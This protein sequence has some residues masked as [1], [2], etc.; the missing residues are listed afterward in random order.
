M[1]QP[2]RKRAER[3]HLLGL[4]QQ[5]F[6]LSQ[7]R[8]DGLQDGQCGRGAVCQHLLEGISANL[9]H[10]A[11]PGGAHRGGP[12]RM[13]Q[14]RHFAEHLAALPNGNHDV[15]DIGFLDNL[16][17][18]VRHHI[19]GVARCAL[20]D[21]RR[22]GA[23]RSTAPCRRK[24]NRD[25]AR[26][27]RR[28]DRSGAADPCSLSAQISLNGSDRNAAL[29]GGACHTVGGAQADVAGGEDARARSSPGWRDP[30]PAASPWAACRPSS[31]RS[32]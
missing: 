3:R 13:I 27:V 26:I 32:L 5:A 1:R 11:V 20:L 29:T 21:Q 17:F 22:T 30:D 10:M 28:T 14:Q 7:P 18:S 6:V 23:R 9:E 12:R 25:P 24:A 16:K 4:S 8:A 31:G 2:G 19:G 15:L